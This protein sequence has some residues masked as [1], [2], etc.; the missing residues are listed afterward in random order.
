MSGQKGSKP[1]SRGTG[2]RQAVRSPFLWWIPAMLLLII[3]GAIVWRATRGGG[4]PPSASGLPGPAGGGDIAQ[5]V[6]TMI[7]Q[8]APSFTLST[9][10][11][12]SY[13]IRPGRGR[14]MVLVFHM[15]IT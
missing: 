7:G 13:E 9:A 11:G 1:P 12:Q 4:P 3:G 15:G 14:P 6:N 2:R 10:E 5:D 8:A